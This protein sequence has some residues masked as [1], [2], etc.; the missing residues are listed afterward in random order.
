MT[1]VLIKPELAGLKH[2]SRGKVREMYDLGETL[3][4][5][6]TDRISAFDVVLPDG[7]PHKGRVLNMLSVFWFDLLKDVSPTHF[8]TADVDEMPAEVRQHKAVLQGRSMLVKKCRPFPVEC[9]VRGYL[10]G[11]GWKDYQKTGAVCGV[12]LPAGLQQAAKL[13]EPIF[14]PATKAESGHDENIDFAQMSKVVGERTATELRDRTL[15]IYRKASVHAESKGLILC[16]TKF[17][18]GDS[19]GKI[20]LIDEVLTPDSS[21]FWPRDGYQVGISPPS[22]DKQFVRDWLETT[23]WDKTPPAPRLPEEVAHRT[24]EKYLEAYKRLT[25]KSLV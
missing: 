10:A 16:D 17:E 5:V 23:K 18:F 22:Y 8:L 15:A 11:S 4:I 20:L 19:D 3:L 6:T 14:T 2:V 13:P 9:V 25:G 24:S 21:R 1:D 12:K 7:I